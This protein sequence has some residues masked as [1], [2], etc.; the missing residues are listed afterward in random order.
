[1]IRELLISR[2]LFAN[3]QLLVP[4]SFDAMNSGEHR[5]STFVASAPV[6]SSCL[7]YSSPYATLG[8]RRP[9]AY[10]RQDEQLAERPESLDASN[11]TAIG[12]ENR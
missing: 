7:A 3:A 6:F 9:E 8:M 1:M 10:Y 4:R 2:T 5:I 11:R 12:L